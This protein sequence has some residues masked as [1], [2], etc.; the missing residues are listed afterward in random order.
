MLAPM[1]RKDQRLGSLARTL[2]KLGAPLAL[3]I[4]T[5][6][7]AFG[8]T[9]PNNRPS[10][11]DPL[12]RERDNREMGHHDDYGRYGDYPSSDIHT[13]VEANARTAF[14][15]ATYHRLQDSLNSAIRQ[16]QYNFEHSPEYVD[17]LKTEQMAWEDYLAARS[18]ALRSVVSDPKYQANVAL[19]HE[20]GEEIAEVRAA[21]DAV[22]PRDTRAAEIHDHLKMKKLV[23]LAT[24]KLDYAQVA[25]DMEV[26]ALKNDPKVADTRS[27]LMSAGA[28]VSALREKFDR[29]VRNSEELASLRGRIEDA[30]IS[31]ITAEAFRDGAVEAANTA[32]D[33]TYYKNRFS[34]N[35]VGYEYGFYA[36]YNG[37]RN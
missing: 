16:M 30:R 23:V 7:A 24:V 3:A 19:K 14:A 22:A 1:S 33:Y 4:M 18:V 35:Y 21:Y 25:T 5:A 11:D 27:K 2:L 37:G 12:S 32:L 29:T 34:G 26:A 10:T 8:Q 28:R 15:R 20:L 13:A 31:L 6:G 9:K 17:A 36:G